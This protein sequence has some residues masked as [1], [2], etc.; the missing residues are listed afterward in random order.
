MLG[1]K[2]IPSARR[3]SMQEKCSLDLLIY[4]RTLLT[5]SL[6]PINSALERKI[7]LGTIS[8]L[9]TSSSISYPYVV[10]V[11]ITKSVNS[12]IISHACKF[13]SKFRKYL[14]LHYWNFWRQFTA[15]RLVIYHR[16]I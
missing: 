11:M 12:M 2:G 16:L 6:A 15:T 5:S 14:H 8:T 10:D 3:Y 1:D 7:F 13:K 4:S 9:Q